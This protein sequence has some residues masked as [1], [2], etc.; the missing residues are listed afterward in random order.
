MET[1]YTGTIEDLLNNDQ[2]MAELKAADQERPDLMELTVAEIVQYLAEESGAAAMH[3]ANVEAA[4]R[5]LMQK[6]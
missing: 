2:L 5:C 3:Q 4:I 6:K 1:I